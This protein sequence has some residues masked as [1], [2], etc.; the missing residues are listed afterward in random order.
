MSH[1]RY[2]MGVTLNSEW[3]IGEA[4][5][6]AMDSWLHFLQS[7][8]S[9]PQSRQISFCALRRIHKKPNM[10]CVSVPNEI[11]RPTVNSLTLTVGVSLRVS[12]ARLISHFILLRCFNRTYFRFSEHIQSFTFLIMCTF[13]IIQLNSFLCY[14][15]SSCWI[16]NQQNRM[17]SGWNDRC[18]CCDHW[19]C[20]VYFFEYYWSND[21]H[22]RSHRRF[23]YARHVVFKVIM[24]LI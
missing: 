10:R 2:S 12:L 3:R 24:P 18:L 23:V 8:M 17:S 19:L 20:V 22:V 4:M 7:R 16:L 9:R 5:A 6:A 11:C 1:T 21:G 14:H 13:F 15:S